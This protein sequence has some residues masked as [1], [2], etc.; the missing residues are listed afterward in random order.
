MEHGC[1]SGV[2][3]ELTRGP[4]PQRIFRPLPAPLRHF[5]QRFP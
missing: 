2:A 1:G 4:P 5:A 3:S